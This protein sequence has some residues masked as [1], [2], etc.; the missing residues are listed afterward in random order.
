MAANAKRAPQSPERAGSRRWDSWTRVP[1]LWRADRQGVA[2]DLL[3]IGT[4]VV[5]ALNLVF[6]VDPTNQFFATFR[7]TALSFGPTSLG[8]ASAADFV[9]AHALLFAWITAL[10]TAYLA[11]AFLLGVTT[12]LACVLGAGA[13]ILFLLTQYYSTFTVPGGT[14]VGPHPLYLVIYLVLF[15]GGAGTYFSIDRGAWTKGRRR[16]PR[17]SRWV[18]SPPD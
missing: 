10:F 2:I 13:S 4:G 11:V 5:W 1:E 14:D 8:G 9:A 7:Y 6:I 18:T 15:T 3:R 17:L 16:F 12:R